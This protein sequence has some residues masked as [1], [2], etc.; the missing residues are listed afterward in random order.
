MFAGSCKHPITVNVGCDVDGD[1]GRPRHA[2]E[3]HVETPP[4]LKHVEP[5]HKR[6][7]NQL[8]EI[9]A[10]HRHRVEMSAASRH[11]RICN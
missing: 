3:K 6:D 8:R 10:V 4:D 11:A 2:A 5:E 9:E 7:R 1:I